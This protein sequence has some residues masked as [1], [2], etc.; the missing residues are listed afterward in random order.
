LNFVEKLFPGA[1]GDVFAKY[2]HARV[3]SHLRMQATI[4]QVNHCARVAGKLSA[5][6]GIEFFRRGIYLGRIDMEFYGFRS[7]LW[8]CQRLV[9]SFID[10]AVDLV[11]Y[12]LKFILIYYI[13]FDQHRAQSLYWIPFSIWAR[14]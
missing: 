7:W 4:N 1:I 8:T 2:Y 9:N 14:C 6:L 3:A 11:L 10:L 5:L 13:F 12:P